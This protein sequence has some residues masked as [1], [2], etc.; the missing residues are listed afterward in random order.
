MSRVAVLVVDDSVVVRRLVTRILDEDP[1]IHVVGTA[2]NGII[3]LEKV[4]SLSPDLVTLD[5][6]M[7][8]MDGL[9]TLAG[10]RKLNPKL[11]VIMFSTL[12]ERA[13]AK[14][15]DALARGA[16]DYVTKPTQLSNLDEA[17]D[18]VR[19]QLIPKIKALTG[20]R[21]SVV[22]AASQQRPVNLPRRHAVTRSGPA[23]RPEVLAIGSSTGGPDALA[24]IIAALPANFPVPIV[25][26]Q[27]M[28]PVFTRLF[29][30]RL[31]RIASI[32]VREAVNGEPLLPGV[33]LIAPGN[34]HLSL[35]REGNHVV[36][37]LSDGPQE[38]HCRPAVDVL[39]RAVAS[40][41]GAH[42]LAVVLTGMGQDGTRGAE[43]ITDAGGGVWAQDQ[44]TSVVWGMPGAV[45]NAGFAARILPGHA[46]GPAL[47][48]AIVHPAGS[49][50]AIA[51]NALSNAGVGPAGAVR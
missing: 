43:C 9:E 41:Y 16:S 25:A 15:L 7:P 13:A 32:T 46:I 12:T 26:V 1:E 33:M 27:H 29:A 23:G 19:S 22:T 20:R 40:V 48:S 35:R 49:G 51:A 30:E 4:A 24:T 31:H 10:I 28:P 37:V 34:Q 18:A 11:P 42:A 5:I 2:A 39:F 6:E 50:N 36:T 44:A 17:L 14:T 8:E 21:S 45:V 38:N 3:A 47:V